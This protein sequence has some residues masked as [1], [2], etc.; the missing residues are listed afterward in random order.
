MDS[1]TNIKRPEWLTDDIVER[2]KDNLSRAIPYT[3]EEY[4][5]AVAEM[6]FDDPYI[7]PK[8][9]AYDAKKILKEYGLI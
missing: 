1:N 7:D 8:M 2:L 9:I 3:D 4:K 5:K 6:W